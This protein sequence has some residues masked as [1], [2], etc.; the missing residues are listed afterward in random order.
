MQESKKLMKR[1]LMS[2]SIF[3]CLLIFVIIFFAIT[4]KNDIQKNQNLFSCLESSSI[5]TVEY[6]EG[7]DIQ[8]PSWLFSIKDTNGKMFQYSIEED[9][10]TEK[11]KEDYKLIFNEQQLE[12]RKNE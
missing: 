8:E 11:L 10:L 2:V 7:D 12:F 1:Q 6:Q 3:G 9:E 4:M 5:V